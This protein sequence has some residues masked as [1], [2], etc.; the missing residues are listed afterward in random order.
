MKKKTLFFTLPLIS[1]FV[2]TLHYTFPFKKYNN[3]VE[4]IYVINLDKSKDR[5]E[6]ISK[7]LETQG[8]KFERFPAILGL[9]LKFKG[10]NGKIFTG[11]DLK[12]KKVEFRIG[13]KY[14]VFCPHITINYQYKP[15]LAKGK[16]PMSAGEFG[17]Y[18]SHLEIMLD[19]VKNAHKSVLVFEDDT[20][21]PNNLSQKLQEI[22]KEMPNYKKY[23]LIFLGYA[24]SA[25]KWFEKMF[26]FKKIPFNNSLIKVTDYDV[27]AGGTHAIIYSYSGAARMLSNL[28]PHAGIDLD[29][30]REV[31]QNT[32]LK[33]FIV[34][35]FNI[36]QNSQF[37]SEIK[38]MGRV[39]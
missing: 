18:C 22:A 13:E 20:S 24:T 26:K 15:N 30:F 28:K 5:L 12:S 6:K 25:T 16:I 38:K 3:P 33:T 11:K 32:K 10:Q 4:K 14:K 2:I 23:D 36:L 35:D 34:R 9:D 29:I 21:I 31:N 1:F 27:S 17:I 39:D 7:D 37:E 8:L 19:V